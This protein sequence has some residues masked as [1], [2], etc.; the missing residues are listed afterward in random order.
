MKETIFIVEDDNKVLAN[1]NTALSHEFNV[2]TVNCEKTLSQAIENK[3]PKSLL[4]ATNGLVSSASKFS[5]ST[6]SSL[7][8][9]PEIIV[10]T[11]Q[12]CSEEELSSY[13]CDGI[14]DSIT[15][16]VQTAELLA[17][18]KLS[19]ARKNKELALLNEIKQNQDMIFTTMKQSSQYSLV[20]AF[21][22]NIALCTSIE[23]LT[24][25]FF[26]TMSALELSATLRLN[27]P[28]VQY[29]HPQNKPVSIIER[30][31][32]EALLDKGRLFEFQKRLIVNDSNVSFLIKHI[33][34]DEAELGQLKDYCAALVEGLEAKVVELHTQKGIDDAASELGTSINNLK[35]WIKEQNFI[36]NSAMSEMMMEIATS[37]HE[38]DMTDI[39]ENFLTSLIEKTTENISRAEIHLVNV[40]QELEEVNDSMAVIT[41]SFKKAAPVFDTE[42][43]LF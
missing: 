39:Q 31:V 41:S 2:V 37:Y 11:T 29:Y 13:Y 20:M 40:S 22:K 18:V 7:N 42:I 4:L 21:F 30:N 34:E 8:F 28:N 17:R 38:L 12:A 15:A 23:E 6:I 26:E 10:V 43:E 36:V 9:V 33:P 24:E 5:L 25:R 19:V 14:S 35:G 27:L 1:Y 3:K 32:Y 16:P